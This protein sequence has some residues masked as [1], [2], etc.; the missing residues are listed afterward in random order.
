MATK[1]KK[2]ELTKQKI[3]KTALGLFREQGFT[4]TT[5]RDIAREAGLSLGAAYHYFP[6]KDALVMEYYQWIQ[7]EHE[8]RLSQTHDRD[9]QPGLQGRVA[10][11]L[12]T[13]LELLKD[14]HRL[15]TAL[16][17]NMADP[18]A[19]LS[20]FSAETGEIRARSIAQFDEL[21]S[22][23]RLDDD[24]KTLLGRAA[25]CAHLCLFLFFIHD[26]SDKQARTLRLADEIAVLTASV[27]AW[28]SFPLARP[29]C[30]RLVKLA[31]DLGFIG[32]RET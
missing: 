20:V 24:V 3:F 4:Q 11:L 23:C 21:F 30:T 18:A 9:P 22:D 8:N 29:I 14:D 5:M 15:L 16:F 19:S 1:I 10:R 28:L 13:K 25:W 27:V 6:S 17:R 7:N 2:R 12:H 31:K 32:E 26:R